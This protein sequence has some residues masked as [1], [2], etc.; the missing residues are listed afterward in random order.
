M[1]LLEDLEKIVKLG[2]EIS[3]S[4]GKDVF[5]Y[6][7]NLYISKGFD[8]DQFKLL[9]MKYHLLKQ[10]Y[11]NVLKLLKEKEVLKLLIASILHPN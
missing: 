7:V 1:N 11:L 2:E 8:E 5:L 4:K 9:L 3:R 6:Y 10:E